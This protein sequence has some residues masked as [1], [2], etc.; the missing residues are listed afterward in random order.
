MGKLRILPF[1]DK[2][3]WNDTVK[4][5]ERHDVYYLN[6]YVSAFRYASDGTPLLLDYCGN[7]MRLCY[8]VQQR[9][10]AED[11]GFCGMLEQGRYYDWSTPYGYGGPLTE[12]LNEPDLRDFFRLLYEYCRSNRIVSQ[13]IRFHP[14]LQN[15]REFMDFCAPRRLKQTV[16]MDTSS[17]E[18]IDANLEA[19]NRGAIKKA[20]KAGVTIE[21][22]NGKEARSEFVSMY[23]ETMLRRNAAGYY[24]FS[25]AFFDDFF[26]NMEGRYC[27]FR[28][29]LGDRTVSSAVILYCN[30][31][32]HYHLSASAWAYR[33]FAPNNL[34]LYT[35]A[36]RG[37]EKGYGKFHLGGGVENEDSLLLFKRSFNKSGL[38]DFYIGRT[39]FCEEAYRELLDIRAASDPQFE[40]ENPFLI[41]YR[42]RQGGA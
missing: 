5:F 20:Q 23:R 3:S 37:T 1:C 26:A 40:R 27:L 17:R 30:G 28:A 39:I 4:S 9:D 8:A 35:A 32:M 10:I 41:Q 7:S 36:C 19:R 12:R 11:A 31:K 16:F 33:S 21:T 29:L 13:F 38:I 34:L 14:L 18:S 24:F 6:E 22:G 25:D 2:N 15:Q 42:F